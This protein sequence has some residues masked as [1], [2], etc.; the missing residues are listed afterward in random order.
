MSILLGSGGARPA[1]DIYDVDAGCPRRLLELPHGHSVYAIALDSHEL[2]VAAVGTKGGRVYWLQ[3]SRDNE[4][5]TASSRVFTQGASVLSIDFVQP[6]QVVASDSAGR[7]LLWNRNDGD[8]AA[9]LST[10]GQVVCALRKLDGDMLAGVSTAGAV[11]SWDLAR[12]SSPRILPAPAPSPWC[13]LVR[14][15]PWPQ[16]SVWAYPSCDGRLVFYD[17]NEHQVRCITA[18]DGEYYAVF[19]LNDDLIT[20]GWQDGRLKR[21]H[22]GERIPATQMPAPP[23]VISAAV[24]SD[25]DLGL[26]LVRESGE[27]GAYRLDSDKL[28][29]EHFVRGDF[30]AVAGPPSD[31]VHAALARHHADEARGLAQCIKASLA[32]GATEDVTE[33]H[34]RLVELQYEH[35][36]LLLRAEQCRLQEDFVGELRAYRDLL[37]LLPLGAR[38]S[39]PS[40]A[41]YA[42]LLERAWQ[43]EE[44]CNLL[45]SAG[46]PDNGLMSQFER[47]KSYS[48][49]LTEADVVVQS[50]TDVGVILA[51]AGVLG[52]TLTARFQIHE[53]PAMPCR[54]VKLSA[55]QIVAKYERVRQEEAGGLPP[56]LASRV[57]WLTRQAIEQVDLVTFDG[58]PPEG[59]E[60]LQLALKVLDAGLQAVVVPVIL[61]DARRAPTDRLTGRE[62]DRSSNQTIRVN[63]WI[64]PIHR[65]VDLSLRMLISEAI[66]LRRCE[67]SECYVGLLSK[68]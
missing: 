37:G 54:E 17:P 63:S 36:S 1:V 34:T 59:V 38:A 62:L 29:L 48:T 43:H 68:L 27:V 44:A 41:H 32:K 61:V 57:T 10:D 35:V 5:T 60:G 58:E 3:E 50:D 31:A 30:R 21:W 12:G 16:A 51:V 20:I 45:R 26:L 66:A 28:Q 11:V 18:H 13:A 53:L 14:L 65:A 9:H 56:A 7:C 42:T 33:L 4:S 24:F 2:N 6:D 39:L 40:V 52:K 23:G 15:T 64:A 67:R 46:A 47:L 22:P 49:A 19:V 55:N 25:R 8:S